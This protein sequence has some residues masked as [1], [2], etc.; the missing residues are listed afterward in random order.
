MV[1]ANTVVDYNMAIITVVESFVS[2]RINT[3]RLQSLHKSTPSGL[4]RLAHSSN[5]IIIFTLVIIYTDN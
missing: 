4:M 3:L 2:K 5:L 1:V